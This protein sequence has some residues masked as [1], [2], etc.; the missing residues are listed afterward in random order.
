MI[1]DPWKSVNLN[2]RKN[3]PA[4]HCMITVESFA[5]QISLF[6]ISN[7]S[8]KFFETMTKTHIAVMSKSFSDPRVMFSVSARFNYS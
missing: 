4:P 6:R 1:G 3:N 5:I 8:K 2:A 7:V